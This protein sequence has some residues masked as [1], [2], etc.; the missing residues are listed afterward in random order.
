VLRTPSPGE[1]EL[2]P[3]GP[4]AGR[5]RYTRALTA[6][7]AIIVA[8]AAWWWFGRL[9]AWVVVASMA[10][11]PFAALLARDRFRNLGHAVVEGR[12]V[13]QLGSLVR[14]RSVLNGNG[15]VGVTLRRSWFQ[16]RNH[17]TSLIATTAAG[18]QKYAV[19]D[20][21][22]AAALGLAL[23]LLP[24]TGQFVTGVTSRPVAPDLAGPGALL[25]GEPGVTRLPA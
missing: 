15:I 13:T 8:L 19:P 18:Q 22:D 9:P 20:L 24:V 3:R 17:L 12:L 10:A 16:R 7:V 5:R 23:Q 2:I 6:T 1:A 25:R 21:D 14:R 4:A 11:L